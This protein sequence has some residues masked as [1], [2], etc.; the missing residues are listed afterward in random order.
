MRRREFVEDMLVVD[1]GREISSGLDR[2]LENCSTKRISK[3]LQ[4]F[5]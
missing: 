3:G 1:I 4:G 2:E 5:N